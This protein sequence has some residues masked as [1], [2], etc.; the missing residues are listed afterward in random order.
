M[1]KSVT[2]RFRL[3][4]SKK[5]CALVVVRFECDG[6]TEEHRPATAWFVKF[7]QLMTGILLT[8]TCRVTRLL[9]KLCNLLLAYHTKVLMFVPNVIDK[10]YSPNRWTIMRRMH[11]HIRRTIMSR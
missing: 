10:I 1:A 11:Q 6:A 7:L 3:K 2:R 4:G 5:P 8:M 9:L